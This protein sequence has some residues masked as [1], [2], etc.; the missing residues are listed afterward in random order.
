[1]KNRAEKMFT[2][3]E[4]TSIDLAASIADSVFGEEGLKRES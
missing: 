1:M 2:G 3:Q 4:Q